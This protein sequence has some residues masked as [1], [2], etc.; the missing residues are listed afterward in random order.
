MSERETKAESP[1]WS[2]D[3][4]N[5]RD[6]INRIETDMSEQISDLKKK[7]KLL[8][9]ML[10]DKKIVGEETAKSVEES[11]PEDEKLAEEKLI[12]WF[13]EERKKEN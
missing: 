5:L 9:R 4:R 2:W 7:I 1:D 10:V 11:T 12:E 3:I 8:V 6:K 13:L